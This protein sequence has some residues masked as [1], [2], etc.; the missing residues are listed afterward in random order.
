[1][2]VA[3]F[4]CAARAG[5]AVGTRPRA[6]LPAPFGATDILSYRDGDIDEQ[7]LRLTEYRG[8][9]RVLIAG[10]DESA[11]PRPCAPCARAAAWATST[12]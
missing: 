6:R 10:G 8:V 11:L 5:S 12:T 7:V 3:A 9:D 1:M 4:R 2:A